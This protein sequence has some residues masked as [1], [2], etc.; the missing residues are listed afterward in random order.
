M[1]KKSVV[2]TSENSLKYLKRLSTIIDD[3]KKNEVSTEYLD[4]LFLYPDQIVYVIDYRSGDVV[5]CRGQQVVLGYS[6]EEFSSGLILDHYLHPLQKS[7]VHVVSNVAAHLGATGAILQDSHLSIVHKA[8]HKNGAYLTVLRK[9]IVLEGDQS[10]NMITGISFLSDISF[11]TRKDKVQWK[12]EGPNYSSDHLDKL[13]KEQLEVFF[14]KREYQ[15]L[16][17][18]NQGLSS[19]TIAEKLFLS[20]HTVDTHRRNML[21]KSGAKNTMELLNFSLVNEIL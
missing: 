6:V 12:L 21:K 19:K 15:V 8:R 16:V 14:S 17:L 7:I 4:S 20:K 11:L 3:N 1:S 13:V 2:P 18:L 9:T 5:Y 10:G